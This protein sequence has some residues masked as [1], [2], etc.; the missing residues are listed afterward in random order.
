MTKTLLT[1]AFCCFLGGSLLCSP[2]L[3]GKKQVPATEKHFAVCINNQMT[4][5]TSTANTVEEA[6]TEHF[7]TCKKATMFPKPNSKLVEG[8]KIFI[9]NEKEDFA[10]KNVA[11]I[12]FTTEYTEDPN[13]EFGQEIIGQKGAPGI[14]QV[15]YRVKTD[16]TLIE[17]GRIHKSAPIKQIIRRGIKD[18]IMT[19]QG[20]LHYKK[21]YTANV[22]AYTIEDGTGDGITSTLI[23][24]Y[25]GVIAVDPRFIPYNSKIYIPGYGV[26]LA[27]DC[28]GM[29]DDNCI[30]LF[31]YDRKQAW[32]WG[33]RHIDVY[34]LD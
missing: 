14:D 22:T 5:Y 13:V 34:L 10:F 15:I 7:I 33:R 20:R 21:K 18:T 8:T 28:G 3:A 19:E 12:P 25:E 2:A 23:V 29:I 11:D 24:P 30:D 1:A 6:L 27:A 17:L 4:H 9:L 26:G 31:M 32:A 16:G